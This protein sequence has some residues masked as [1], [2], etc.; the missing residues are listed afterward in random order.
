MPKKKS[1]KKEAADFQK[2]TSYLV[3]FVGRAEREAT[4]D[5]DKSLLYEAAIIKLHSAFE[6]LI[7]N[8]L[9]GAINNDTKALSQST[10]IH[11]PKH[12]TDE[13]CEYIVI[14]GGYFDFR[15][16]DGLVGHLRQYLPSDHYLIDVVK[17]NRY[18]RT[19][20]RTFALR[21]FAAHESA[22]GKKAARTAV[23]VNLS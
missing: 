8:G 5:R 14:G 12:L 19:L 4:S 9:V 6:R 15:G 16:R 17:N 11:F 2:T 20:E 3:A 23:G 18:K 1:V 21:N 13:V 7:L 22:Q 10:G